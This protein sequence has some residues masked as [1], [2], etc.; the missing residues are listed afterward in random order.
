MPKITITN[1]DIRRGVR[2]NAC[3]CP[4]ALAIKRVMPKATSV[5]VSCSRVTYK[6][7]DQRVW[8]DLPKEA[9]VFIENFD[10]G[11][12]VKPFSFSL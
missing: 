7:G 1:E 11:F 6:V 12:K 8:K 2:N 5:A 4:V 3:A 9:Y 10:E